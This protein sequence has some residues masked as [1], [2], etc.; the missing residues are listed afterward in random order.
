MMFV[1]AGHSL[2]SRIESYVP[3]TNATY[4][5]FAKQ[6][7][8]TESTLQIWLD[9]L[10]EDKGGQTMFSK[11]GSNFNQSTKKEDIVPLLEVIWA[12]HQQGEGGG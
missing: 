3:Y 7:K 10:L 9:R 12:Q 2:P 4:E 6:M 5:A 8:V 1:F 11:R